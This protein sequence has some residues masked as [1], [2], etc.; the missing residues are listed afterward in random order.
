MLRLMGTI[1]V[2]ISRRVAITCE[3]AFDNNKK[4]EKMVNCLANDETECR[5]GDKNHSKSPHRLK[6]LDKFI[7]WGGC[8]KLE[9]VF[10]YFLNAMLKF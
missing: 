1:R 8:G 6:R 5:Q 10:I 4:D 9:E 3:I 2:F 7:M